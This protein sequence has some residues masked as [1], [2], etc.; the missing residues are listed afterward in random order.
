MSLS[1]IPRHIKDVL[2]LDITGR[3]TIY[4]DGLRDTIRQFVSQGE[5][6]IVLNLAGVPYMD[7][8]G[9]G[10]RVTAYTT[11]LNAGGKLRLLAP[12]ERVRHLLKITKLDSVFTILEN[13]DAIPGSSSAA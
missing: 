5:R 8:G 4:D 1:L 12:A 7:S 11:V 3:V 10:Q 9:L 6:R 13:E 2:V